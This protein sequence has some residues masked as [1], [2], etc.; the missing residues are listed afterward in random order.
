MP[1]IDSDNMLL[2]GLVYMSSHLILL[3]H[4]GGQCLLGFVLFCFVFNLWW[5]ERLNHLVKVMKLESARL[6][7]NLRVVSVIAWKYYF[8]ITVSPFFSF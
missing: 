2:R 3:S 4:I 8:S 1:D 6:R 5:S 7:S